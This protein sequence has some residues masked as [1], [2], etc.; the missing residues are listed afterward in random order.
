MQTY[1]V[2][3]LLV[4]L[5]AVVAALVTAI[6]SSNDHEESKTTAIEKPRLDRGCLVVFIVPGLG[7]CVLASLLVLQ[8]ESLTRTLAGMR[9]PGIASECHCLTV[10][11][12]A[13]REAFTCN[14]TMLDDPGQ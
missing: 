7:A 5:A 11:G 12:T 2:G 8:P 14:Q 6:K 3:A 13:I 9:A 10:S 4:L 1:L